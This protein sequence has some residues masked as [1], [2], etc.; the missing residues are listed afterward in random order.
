MALYMKNLQK[1][2]LKRINICNNKENVL[3][4]KSN[5]K[6]KVSFK[7]AKKVLSLQKQF[8]TF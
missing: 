6:Q 8:Y 1:C 4:I 5:I 2:L 3:P 7:F